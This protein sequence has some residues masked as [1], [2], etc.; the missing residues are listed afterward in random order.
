VP[1]ENK[2]YVRVN[3]RGRE[4][5]GI[6][7]P[8]EL[9]ALLDEITDGL[10]TFRDQDGTPSISRIMRTQSVAGGGS[11]VE[12]LPDLVVF[13]GDAPKTRL[14]RVWSPAHGEIVRDGV[15]SGRSGN[16]V[17]DAWS[18]LLPGRSRVRDNGRP[19]RVTD[20]G[21]TVCALLGADPVGLSGAPLLEARG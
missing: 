18:L 5:D 3:L 14:T 6:V 11:A 19:P 21:A 10:L 9:D 4:R 1:G 13:W 15:G 20:I 8:S 2:G 17:D 7:E 12:R 16:H